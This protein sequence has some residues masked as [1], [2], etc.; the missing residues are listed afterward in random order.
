[1]F[2]VNQIADF[3]AKRIF[4]REIITEG[5]SSNLHLEIHSDGREETFL[6]WIKNAAVVVIPRFSFDI[7]SSGISTYLCAM[8]AW[9]CV[10]ISKGPGA[11]DI[12]TDQ[13]AIIVE[14]ENADCLAKAIITA[15][16]DINL[17]KKIAI[18]G[19]RYAEQLQ[20]E[21]RLLTDLLNLVRNS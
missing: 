6:K 15:W 5:F 7:S 3:H 18:S 19:R 12:L 4:C 20:G 14:P 13:Q 2:C 17:R 16:N 9:R 10:I 21:E 11:H 8:A 1:L